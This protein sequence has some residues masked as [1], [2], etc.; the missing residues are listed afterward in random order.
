MAEASKTRSLLNLIVA[1]DT[2]YGIG[3][4]GK[5]PWPRLATDLKHFRERT[6]KATDSEKKN[7]IIAARKTWDSIPAR[8]RRQLYGK[9]SFK[10]VLSRGPPVDGADITA[11]SLEN[12]MTILSSHPQKDQFDSFWV[13]G[14]NVA[15]SQALS[16]PYPIKLYVTFLKASFQCD[17]FFPKLNWSEW[18]EI[19][20]PE[21]ATET[22]TEQGISY[23]FK[24]Y[25]R[26]T[27]IN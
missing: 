22:I 18:K 14:G 24:I 23:Q 10:V 13:I 1:F 17:A 12:A 2:N 4:D 25:I 15:Y 27:D 26:N 19:Y 5:I 7:V 21:V 8:T 16:S 6:T 9:K 11:N 3:N 20:E